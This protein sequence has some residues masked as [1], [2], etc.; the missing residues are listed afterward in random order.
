M[1]AFLLLAGLALAWAGIKTHMALPVELGIEQIRENIETDIVTFYA[2]VR[3]AE[4]SDYRWILSFVNFTCDG[5]CAESTSNLCEPTPVLNPGWDSRKLD[6]YPHE[7]DPAAMYIRRVLEV[8]GEF[9]CEDGLE[10]SYDDATAVAQLQGQLFLHTVQGCS[11]T[12]CPQVVASDILPFSLTYNTESG[13]LNGL[14]RPRDMTYIYSIVSTKNIWL[15]GYDTLVELTS[16]VQT[17]GDAEVVAVPIRFEN[18]S[19]VSQSMEPTMRIVGLTDCTA[20]NDQSGCFQNWYLQADTGLAQPTPLSGKM[21]I[22]SDLVF[23]DGS[24]VQS[25]LHLNIDVQSAIDPDQPPRLVD[26]MTSVSGRPYFSGM[27]NPA[28][29]QRGDRICMTLSSPDKATLTPGAVRICAS[30]KVD[31]VADV[32]EFTGCRTPNIDDLVVYEIV[33]IST[34]FYNSSFNPTVE[35]SLDSVHEFKVC[36]DAVALSDKVEVIEAYYS[37]TDVIATSSQASKRQVN[38]MYVAQ[39]VPIGCAYSESW[40]PVMCRCVPYYTSTCCDDGWDW[41]WIIFLIGL[42][43]LIMIGVGVVC[44]VYP[45][46]ESTTTYP[47]FINDGPRVYYVTRGNDGSIHRTMVV[48]GTGNTVYNSPDVEPKWGMPA[49]QKTE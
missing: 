26:T 23:S 39:G 13:E 36:F 35:Q 10:W 12:G 30:Q 7:G 46:C 47:C 1:R 41:L 43:L 24:V 42:I 22:I 3:G 34:G 45:S 14:Q 33:D 27:L 15:T 38:E 17:L 37:R 19:I 25:L 6:F 28:E 29:V 32:T 5:S 9:V 44:C 4:N 2:I 20:N 8:D 18:P 16:N 21:E 48:S 49:P 11:E 40:D 31:L